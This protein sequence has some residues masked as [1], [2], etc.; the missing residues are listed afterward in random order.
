VIR[1]V[2][3][4]SALCA[5]FAG[6][7]LGT[8][9]S[10]A[11]PPE[12]TPNPGDIAKFRS[13]YPKT[14]QHSDFLVEVNDRGQVSKVRSGTHSKDP[15]FDAVTYGNVIQTFVRRSD[16]R[17]ISG[18]F[19]VSYDYDPKSEM[20]RRSVA[21][22]HAGGVNAKA[23]GLVTVFAEASEHNARAGQTAA[24]KQNAID[25]QLRN[26]LKNMHTSPPS[27]APR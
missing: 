23:P 14:P 10:A 3:V 6:A 8:P 24:Q 4:Q 15:R 27:A 19:R 1:H 2:V 22:V 18:L 16:G 9:C 7:I 25:E 11:P 17:A 13:N 26:Q 5:L 12:P 21:L 20:V